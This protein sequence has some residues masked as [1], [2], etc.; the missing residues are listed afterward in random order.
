MTLGQID[1]A[2][3]KR[4][5]DEEIARFEASHP[6]SRVAWEEARG[7]VHDGVPLN[8]MTRWCGSFPLYAREASGARLT[9]V[10]GHVYVDLAL[11]DTG[12]LFG[13]AV[14][15]A[16]AAMAR[17]AARGTTMM[18]PTEDAAVVTRNL[19]ERFG[20]PVWQFAVSAT[21]ANRFCLRLARAITGRPKI[22]VFNGCYHG[23]L[24]E[25]LVR[26]QNGVAV[27][28]PD[29]VGQELDPGE[30]TRIVEFNDLDALER[31]L[32]HGDVACVLAEPALTNCGVV[33]PAPGF[34]EGLRD[35]TRRHGVL[36]AM[37][38]T[39]T[40]CCGP[41]GYTAAHGLEPDFLTLGKPIAGGIPTAV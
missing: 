39:H 38:E 9:D 17:Q 15:Q 33:P 8:W 28:H 31:A 32:S 7:S 10:D 37:D 14:P 29:M 27:P 40:I 41:G 12:A 25:A 34:H 16:V 24:A 22:L 19:A 35:L 21:D 5:L 26:S 23:N 2:H 30:T 4:L 36:L 13:H 18:L 11:G 3:V 1:P 20:L 6:A